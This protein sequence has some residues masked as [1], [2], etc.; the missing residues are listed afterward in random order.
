MNYEPP[1]S[2][3]TGTKV[4]GDLRGV[5]GGAEA[6]KKG[7]LM[8]VITYIAGSYLTFI[9]N[10]LMGLH[11]LTEFLLIFNLAYYLFNQ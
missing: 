5:E 7:H 2:H 9:C 10:Q 6:G 11:K 3:L 4:T 1:L 8:K